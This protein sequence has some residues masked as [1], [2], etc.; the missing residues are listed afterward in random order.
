MRD[1]IMNERL[2]EITYEA[3]R[4]Q[5]LVRAG[6]FTV[7]WEFKEQFGGHWV[8]FPIPRTQLDANPNLNQNPGY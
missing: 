5:G 7:A 8:L 2:F 4:R 3:R 6:Q 1:R